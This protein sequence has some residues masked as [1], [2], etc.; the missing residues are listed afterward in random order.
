MTSDDNKDDKIAAE[1]KNKVVRLE[2]KIDSKLAPLLEKLDKKFG[3][4]DTI[5][6]NFEKKWEEKAEAFEKK[7]ME[8]EKPRFWTGNRRIVLFLVLLY[9]GTFYLMTE[10]ETTAQKLSSLTMGAMIVLVFVFIGWVALKIIG[11]GKPPKPPA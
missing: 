8:P 9:M 10:H 5:V 4:V 2:D 3:D 7:M 6:E 1:V 11:D